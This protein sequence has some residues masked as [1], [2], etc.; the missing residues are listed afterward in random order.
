MQ[1]MVIFSGIFE[2]RNS[3]VIRVLIKFDIY[4]YI[5]G[6]FFYS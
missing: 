3:E 2:N 6:Y 1:L 5:D 4:G